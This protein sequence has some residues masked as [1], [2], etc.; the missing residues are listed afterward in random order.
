[1]K[2]TEFDTNKPARIESF[3]R[4]LDNL[5][6]EYHAELYLNDD[7]FEGIEV[8]VNAAKEEINS[9]VVPEIP[10]FEGTINQLR[11]LSI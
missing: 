3:L 11:D 6:Q 4:E 5:V 7:L 1:M 8:V 10:G 2:K 9:S